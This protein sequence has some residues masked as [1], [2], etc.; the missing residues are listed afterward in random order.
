MHLSADVGLH[1]LAKVV[2]LSAGRLTELF[3]EG[4]GEPPHRWLMNRRLTRACEL[5][6]NP[7]LTITEIAHE[8][9]FASSQHFSVV[10]R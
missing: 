1:E 5:L 6:A 3:R 7:S 2:G 10:M 8:C 9:G 4:T